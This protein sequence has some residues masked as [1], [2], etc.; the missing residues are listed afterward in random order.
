M[1]PLPPNVTPGAVSGLD[2]T[3]LDF[4]AAE[5]LAKKAK[6]V[7]AYL[8]ENPSLVAAVLSAEKDGKARKTILEGRHAAA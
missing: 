7:N 6:D 8:D 3:P 2:N 5:V 1:A 4:D